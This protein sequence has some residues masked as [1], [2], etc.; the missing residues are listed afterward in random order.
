LVDKKELAIHI[1][2]LENKKTGEYEIK[3]ADYNLP[4][5][6]KYVKMV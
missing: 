4:A 3:E 2:P 5:K 6:K 1:N